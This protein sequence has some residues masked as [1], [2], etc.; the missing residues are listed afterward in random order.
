[1][2]R[3]GAFFFSADAE[4]RSYY[5]TLLSHVREADRLG[6]GFVSTPERHFDPFGGP[7]PNPAVLSAALAIATSRLQ[8]RAGSLISPLHNLPRLIEDWSVVDALSNGRVAL[9][10]G[11]G[12]NPVDF[13]LAPDA[14]EARRDEVGAHLTIIPELWRSRTYRGHLPDGSV[15]QVRLYPFPANPDL[16]MWLTASGSIDTFRLAGS[17]GV[18]ILTHLENQDLQTL[19]GKIDAYRAA[20]REAGHD[21]EA[22]IVTLM[23]HAYVAETD[24][25]AR[26]VAEPALRLYLGRALNL[27]ERALQRGGR[28]S[29]GRKLETGSFTDSDVRDGVL[30]F[31]VDKYLSRDALI[32]SAETCRRRMMEI[33]EAGVG[34]VACLIDFVEDAALVHG[35]LQRLAALQSEPWASRGAPPAMPQP[36]GAALGGLQP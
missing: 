29:G 8:I 2:L 36:A 7:F 25:E 3:L 24:R 17:K 1:M 33:A 13:L 11:S 21:A 4:N 31:A 28:M 35:S 18:N 22:G 20:R 9:S 23:Q 34:E 6:F 10:L 30:A 19:S 14:F 26:A 32:G 12:W 27:E 16:P 5:Q 15:K